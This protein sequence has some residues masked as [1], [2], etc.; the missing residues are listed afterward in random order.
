MKKSRPCHYEFKELLVNASIGEQL[1]PIRENQ[2]SQ[3]PIIPSTGPT[4]LESQVEKH[5]V[6]AID[7][8]SWRLK[9]VHRTNDSQGLY[10]TFGRPR[11]FQG[12]RSQS[13][14][15]P[16]RTMSPK[17]AILC[18]PT[19]IAAHWASVIGYESIDL[20]P[21]GEWLRLAW[22]AAGEDKAISLACEYTLSSMVAFQSRENAALNRT[23]AAGAR[24]IQSLQTAVKACSGPETIHNLILAVLLHCA[25]EVGSYRTLHFCAK[26]SLI[27]RSILSDSGPSTM[28]RTLLELRSCS[29]CTKRWVALSASS[30]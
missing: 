28:C 29:R 25:A 26:H 5:K 24:A 21:L 18:Q 7:A 30:R 8:G 9:Y 10:I 16:P 14:T 22:S 1:L 6:G 2:T 4:T 20:N 12:Q 17:S 23:Y 19:Q 15:H 11:R 13:T 3:T 27:A